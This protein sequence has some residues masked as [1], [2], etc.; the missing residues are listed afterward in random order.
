MDFNVKEPFRYLN[1]ESD[2]PPH[3][4]RGLIRS[5]YNRANIICQ[6]H[7]DLQKEIYQLKQDLLL[8]GYPTSF[9]NSATK[10][11]VKNISLPA[12]EKKKTYRHN[13][14]HVC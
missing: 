12:Q 1:F 14:Y 13:V 9:I 11:K 5:L 6:D 4:K 8:N 3:I 7:Q 2:H 10:E